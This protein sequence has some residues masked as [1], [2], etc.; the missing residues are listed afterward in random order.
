MAHPRLGVEMALKE[1]VLRRSVPHHKNKQPSTHQRLSCLKPPPPWRPRRYGLR[2]PWLFAVVFPIYT[3]KFLTP[4]LVPPTRSVPARGVT[5][6]ARGLRGSPAQGE[7]RRERGT[8][9]HWPPSGRHRW[10]T[11][12]MSNRTQYSLRIICITCLCKPCVVISLW[13]F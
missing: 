10:R 12:Q 6:E 1:K 3:K 9:Y 7:E 5:A 4:C 2:H 8:S 11:R 13:A